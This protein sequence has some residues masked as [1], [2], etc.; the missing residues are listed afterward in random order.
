MKP[1]FT[2]LLL[3]QSLQLLF[4]THNRS[5]YIRYEQTGALTVRAE[6]VTYTAIEVGPADRNA[7]DICWG[8]GQTSRIPRTTENG[9]QLE[10][11]FRR[12]TYVGEHTYAEK[13]EYILCL[14]D[15]NRNAGILNVNPPQSVLVP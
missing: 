2:L 7:L 8:D 6:I 11:G 4:A 1:L 3:A 13:G 12:H 15:P 9:V 5:G 10:N 14:T